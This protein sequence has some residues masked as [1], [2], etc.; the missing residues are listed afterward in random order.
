MVMTE[1]I[2]AIAEEIM[3]EVD[4]ARKYYECS[5]NWAAHADISKMYKD[6]ASQELDHATHLM[7]ILRAIGKQPDVT[8]EETVLINFIVDVGTDQVKKSAIK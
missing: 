6:M 8:S 4:G 5:K 1:K 3:E 7:E 2:K